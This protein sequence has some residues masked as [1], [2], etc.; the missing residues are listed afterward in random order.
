M[1]SKISRFK[2]CPISN[3]Q[4][5]T[6]MD[7]ERPTRSR[8]RRRRLPL[9]P[10]AMPA[11]SHF[12]SGLIYQA[13]ARSRSDPQHRP[14]LIAGL[15][16][17]HAA[18]AIWGVVPPLDVGFAHFTS[19]LPLL[20]KTDPHPFCSLLYKPPLRHSPSLSERFASDLGKRAAICAASRT[21]ARKSSAK[22]L[23][24]RRFQRASSY[25][26]ASAFWT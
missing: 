19:D 15:S 16:A 9:A 11:S 8:G 18:C 24:S 1:R 7:R 4:T 10:R 20:R 5:H 14:L 23:E 2:I 17:C 12:T 26:A 6:H 13:P 21:F 3:G 22:W 25:S